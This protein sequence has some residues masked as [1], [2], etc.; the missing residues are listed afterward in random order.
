MSPMPDFV[1][2]TEQNLPS[3]D[4]NPPPL[5]TNYIAIN[6]DDQNEN[7]TSVTNTNLTKIETNL[8]V[9][10]NLPNNTTDNESNMLDLR[11][12]KFINANEIK[13]SNMVSNDEEILQEMTVA[14]SNILGLRAEKLIGE[15]TEKTDNCD[16]LRDLDER[17]ILHREL[18]IDTLVDVT[19]QCT[20]SAIAQTNADECGLPLEIF[21]H[22]YLC[23]PYLSL[24]YMDLLSDSN[25]R[26]YVV[27]ATNVLFK[28]KKQLVDVLIEIDG[29]RIES[30]DPELRRQLHLT[31][32]DLRFA[33]FLV[34]HVSEERHDVFLDGVGWEGGDEWIRS[35]FKVY[36]LC[37]LRTSLLPGKFRITFCLI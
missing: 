14:D 22:G 24:P 8:L 10:T 5:S 35:Q 15:S 1:E 23:F 28:Q 2:S 18:S 13:V 16:T 37:L 3:Y 31:T 29:G 19:A 11:N 30:Q 9:R 12:E 26:G 17:V 6:S 36:L 21:K 4:S 34:K 7:I 27:G 25:V 32:E 33:D 20:M